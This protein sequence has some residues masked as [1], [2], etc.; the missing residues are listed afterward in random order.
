MTIGSV[1]TRSSLFGEG[2]VVSTRIDRAFWRSCSSFSS[3]LIVFAGLVV[4]GLAVAQPAGAAG[5]GTDVVGRVFN[6][7]NGT[8]V[9]NATV[10]V[11]GTKIEAIT[12]ERG[13]FVLPAVPAGAIRI[14][15][16]YVG[17]PPQIQ[18]VTVSGRQTTVPDIRLT[19]LGRGSLFAGV[20]HGRGRWPGVVCGDAGHSRSGVAG[21]ACGGRYLWGVL[22]CG[23]W[24][25]QMGILA[26]AGSGGRGMIREWPHPGCR[27]TKESH[28]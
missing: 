24:H 19:G 22:L 1:A 6:D 16:F 25:R 17:L 15:A 12:D 11:E 8:Y 7:L 20:W 23:A 2:P 21:A 9:A 3:R 13:A 5:Q 14:R 28:D 4:S 18:S 10:S 27:H 26:V